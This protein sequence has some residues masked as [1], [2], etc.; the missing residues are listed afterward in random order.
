M[1]VCVCVRVCMSMCVC[2]CVCVT[3]RWIL[4]TLVESEFRGL[5]LLILTGPF[6]NNHQKCHGKSNTSSAA[7]EP[8]HFASINIFTQSEQWLSF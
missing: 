7:T 5:A 1:Y 8:K 3:G 2:V 6:G 4:F